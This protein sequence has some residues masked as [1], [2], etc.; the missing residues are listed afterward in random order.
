MPD[1]LDEANVKPFRNNLI[2]LNIMK[3]IGHADDL[4]FRLMYPLAT[5]KEKTYDYENI[6]SN[7]DTMRLCD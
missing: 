4:Q 1:L 6:L 7:D 2:G 5:S 3:V